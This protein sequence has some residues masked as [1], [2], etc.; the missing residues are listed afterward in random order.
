MKK[1]IIILPIIMLT[2]SHTTTCSSK[3][4]KYHDGTKAGWLGVLCGASAYDTL[5]KIGTKHPITGQD[6]GIDSDDEDASK[7][8]KDAVQNLDKFQGTQEQKYTIAKNIIKLVNQKK[9][10]YQENILASVINIVGKEY[11]LVTMM[12]YDSKTKQTTNETVWMTTEE[13]QAYWLKIS[14]PQTNFH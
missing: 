2:I 4:N 8:Y 14:N 11:S 10:T 9:L 12:L 5:L 1:Y 6:Y 13:Q 3:K 7:R